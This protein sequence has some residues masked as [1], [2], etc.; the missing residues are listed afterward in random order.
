MIDDAAVDMPN[1]LVGEIEGEFISQEGAAFITEYGVKKK[2]RVFFL[3]LLQMRLTTLGHLGRSN[4][5]KRP[6]K[7]PLTLMISR[8]SPTISA[9]YIARTPFG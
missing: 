3:I 7:K 8:I 5:Y 6:H 1:W 2:Q 4:T 9:K